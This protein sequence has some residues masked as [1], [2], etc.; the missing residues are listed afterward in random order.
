MRNSLLLAIL[1]AVAGPLAAQSVR[2]R[3]VGPQGGAVP[4]AIIVLTDSAG[5]D[6][7]RM[8]SSAI[9]SYLLRAPGA[10]RYTIQVLRIGYPAFRTSPFT[11]EATGSLELTPTLP[12]DPIILAELTVTGDD[13]CHADESVGGTTATLLEEVKKAFGSADLALR[14]RD[15]RFEVMLRVS[16][17][18]QRVEHFEDSVMQTLRS[19]PVHSL[20]PDQLRDRGFVQQSDSVSPMYVPPG[21]QGRVWFGPDPATLFSA[22]FLATHCYR[23]VT[24]PRD[25]ERVGLKFSPVPGRRLSDISGTLWLRRPTLGLER[26]EYEYV[27][28]P[29]HL[30]NGT[31]IRPSGSMELLKLPSG[32]W[33]VSRWV[34]KAPVEY[35]RNGEPWGVA[36]WLEQGGEIRHIRT[37][38]GA[39]IF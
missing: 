3:I 12:D 37:V 1:A 32:L 18:G 31:P 4:G 2:G 25:A 5:T 22:P 17:D 38:Q 33:I 8:L 39:V 9:G 20:P 13:A 24:D 16:R 27:N 29:R 14:D 34:L 23:V 21:A 11:L 19:W 26:I 35:I 10:G 36:G 6:R 28:F 15:L 7:A 30:S